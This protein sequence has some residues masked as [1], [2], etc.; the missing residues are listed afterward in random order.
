MKKKIY[1][2]DVSSMFFRAY[3]AIRPLTTP[4]GV[5]V[6]AVYGFLSM[7]TKL[8]KEEKPDYMVFTYDRKEPSFR[9]NLYAEYKANRT[10]MPDD[11]A[12]QIPYIKKLADYLGIPALE[13]PDYEADDIIG[14]LVHLG[15]K[16]HNEV[17]IVSGDKDFGQLIQK[18]VVLFDTMK[19]VKYDEA[20]VLEKWG[21]PP[22]K[23]IDY[24]A[25]MGDSSD[26][27]PGVDGIGP[28]GAQKLL[29]QFSSVEDIY[30]NIDKV[31]PKGIREKLIKSKDNA[32]LSK[33]LV[34]ISTDVPVSDNFEDYHLKQ[35]QADNLRALLQEL[36]F[37]SFEKTL[38]GGHDGA[39]S[40]HDSIHGSKPSTATVGEPVGAKGP[41]AH[42]QKSQ[43]VEGPGEIKIATLSSEVMEKVERYLNIKETVISAEALLAKLHDKDALWGFADER[44]LFIGRDVELWAIEGG[45]EAL[46]PGTDAKHIQWSGFDLKTFFHQIKSDHPKVAWDSSLAAYVVRAGDSTDFND[47]YKKF[48]GTTLPEFATPAQVFK[49]HVELQHVLQDRLGLFA[50]EKIVNELELPL[51]PVLLRM[52]NKGIR[53]DVESLQVQSAELTEEI[54]ALEK[55]IQQLAGETFNVGSPKQLGVI[56]FE[57]MNLPS[58]KKTK[59]GY[60]TGEDVLEKIEH[61]IARKIL[62]WREL[63]KLKSTYVDALPEIMMPDGRVH[64]NF[65]Q[66]LTTTGR[67]SSTQPNLQNI[68][69]RTQR[70]QRVRQAF[71]ADRGKKLLSMDYSQIELRILAH[72]SDDPGLLKA[73]REG[74]DIHAATAAEIFNVDLKGVTSDQRR[75]AK[76][77]NFGIAYGQGAF[78][79]A[80]NLGIP[81]KEAKEIIERYFTKFA[82]VREYINNTV[83]LAHENGYVETLFGRRRYI[84][85]LNSKNPMLRKFGERAAINAPIQGTA[86]D[87]VKKAM[88]D[89]GENVPL[90]MLLQVH[91]ELIFEGTESALQQQVPALV[92]IMENVMQLKVPL[93]VN[94]AIG[95]NWDEAH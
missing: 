54:A 64:T 35:I 79:L 11:L 17:V 75:S 25:I 41:V 7:V 5:P 28:K 14:T 19:D 4:A 90:D 30:E 55:E 61:P 8:F 24:L 44:G 69:V 67:L 56:L 82:G 46:G 50:G 60:S 47:I 32:F 45:Y 74:L 43:E 86:S 58:G 10:A 42:A 70:G 3:Y 18:H 81:N 48:I 34:T 31:E 72:I 80:E 22:E 89:I 83:K 39:G 51:V 93:K 27:V 20:G 78:G 94:Y 36:N 88:I 1:L 57:K 21:V 16:H 2:V 9:K 37:K 59:T 6:N 53:I 38:L 23:F 63:S 33:T 87:L 76:A 52:E 66:A 84:E 68:P 85:E 15:L 40:L 65:N 49:A 29:Q 92:T 62:Q 91:D 13:V 26:N 73:F 71:I 77:V 95:N 12:V